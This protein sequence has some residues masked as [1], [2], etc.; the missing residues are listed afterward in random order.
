MDP[1]DSLFNVA[2][3]M[4][5]LSIKERKFLSLLYGK[6]H[7]KDTKTEQLKLY[8]NAI[9]RYPHGLPIDKKKEYD[10]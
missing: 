6:Y 9:E 8:K 7:V 5:S 4:K 1:I 3:F 2:D 10:I